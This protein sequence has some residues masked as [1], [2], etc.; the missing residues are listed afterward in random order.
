MK[1]I[2]KAVL[3]SL[4]ILLSQ[5]SFGFNDFDILEINA[6]SNLRCI[7]FA[8]N[9]TGYIAG[10]GGVLYK[11]T[12][13]GQK[14]AQLSPNWPINFNSKDY[15]IVDMQFLSDDSG[16]VLL[17]HANT[18]SINHYTL[19]TYDGGL[20]FEY[21]IGWTVNGTYQTKLNFYDMKNGVLGG[22]GFFVGNS[23]LKI[24][25]DTVEAEYFFQF[26]YRE[27]AAICRSLKNPEYLMAGSNN[28]HLYHS[29]DGGLNWDTMSSY[30]SS[31]T[32]GV[33]IY[34]IATDGDNWLI[35][36]SNH[37]S[38]YLTSDSGKTWENI[39]TTFAYPT[40]T[41]ISYSKRDSFVAVGYSS[42]FKKGEIS[43]YDSNSNMVYQNADKAL[44]AVAH[45]IN[46]DA[47]V[48]GDSGVVMVK[49][50]SGKPLSSNNKGLKNFHIY[51]NPVKSELNVV[52][53]NFNEVRIFNLHGS[54]LQKIKTNNSVLDLSMLKN[55][56]YVLSV[57]DVQSNKNHYLKFQKL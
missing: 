46:G 57:K 42:S 21:P 30:F 13:N 44:N 12:D 24:S 50:Q 3:C 20:T 41:S 1:N 14:W 45:N 19:R 36:T 27:I 22:G 6:D 43:Y 48:V 26:D 53:L 39:A 49:W 28:G 40:Y 7:S 51:P 37:Q 33:F 38:L 8:P 32:Q 52:G 56:F 9:G 5:L 11:T 47:F 2:K 17:K 54:L 35:S 25:E 10:N 16:Y 15:N 55:G 34:S 29:F 23:F 31:G 4:C 18:K